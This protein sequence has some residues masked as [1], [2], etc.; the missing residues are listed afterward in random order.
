VRKLKIGQFQT[1]YETVS[2]TLHKFNQTRMT[3]LCEVVSIK[4]L[5]LDSGYS[6]LDNLHDTLGGVKKH[7]AS[8][9]QYRAS[10]SDSKVF[11]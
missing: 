8:S 11:H 4:R 5:M 9:N 6:I 3:V 2:L 1:F 10:A 7:R